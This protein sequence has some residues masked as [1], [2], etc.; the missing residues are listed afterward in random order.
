MQTLFLKEDIRSISECCSE[1]KPKIHIKFGEDF[2][3]LYLCLNPNAIHFIEEIDIG[4][5]SYKEFFYLCRNPNA[6][7]L[8]PIDKMLKW[9]PRK[10]FQKY[11]PYMENAWEN[12]CA[13]PNATHITI[14]RL[15]ENLGDINCYYFLPNPRLIVLNKVP[16]S[17]SM[18]SNPNALEYVKIILKNF[19]NLNWDQKD[20]LVEYICLNPNIN[21]LKI[22]NIYPEVEKMV[23]KVKDNYINADPRIFELEKYN[24][25]IFN[26]LINIK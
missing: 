1:Y 26:L 21:I 6:L 23:E 25:K 5:L 13:N 3:Y 2:P 11:R 17:I 4:K 9:D 8:L 12:L 22:L 24:E 18:C 10:F 16:C 19:K 20:R 7:H 14:K 15:K